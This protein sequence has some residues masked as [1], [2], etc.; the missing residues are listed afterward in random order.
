[1]IIIHVDGG[2]FLNRETS[3]FERC[4]FSV[5][6]NEGKLLHFA[7]NIGDYYSGV[8]EFLAIKWAVLNIPERPILITSD[9]LVAI[10]W[11]K[12]GARS[13]QHKASPLDLTGVVLQY[14]HGNLADMWNAQN[15]GGKKPHSYFFRK[16]A[17]ARR[18]SGKVVKLG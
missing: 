9:C 10:T 17:E 6:D 5:L 7:E 11:A 4:Y 8:G 1:M 14:Q 16:W 2:A 12:K 15:H 18:K 3:K 13:K